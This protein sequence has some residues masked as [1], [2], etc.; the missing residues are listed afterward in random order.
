MNKKISILIILF[1]AFAFTVHFAN[2]WKWETHQYLA[3]QVCG[4]DTVSVDKGAIAPDNEFKDF[5]NHH[6]YRQCNSA[7]SAE[8]C[9]GSGCFDC[10]KGVITD[11]VATDKVQEWILKMKS[12]DVLADKSYDCGVASHYFFDSKVYFHQTKSEKEAC[13]TDFEANVNNRIKLKDYGNW[14]ECACGVCVSYFEFNN[15][16]NQFDSVRNST[17]I[18][19]VITGTSVL[20]H[21]SSSIETLSAGKNVYIKF[22]YWIERIKSCAGL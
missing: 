13:H 11:N 3:E 10:S 2:A 14:T 18:S 4:G 5:I 15:W 7:L 22:M 20:G 21:G 9:D 17:T 19:S 1:F 6:V 8:W 16:I 12:T